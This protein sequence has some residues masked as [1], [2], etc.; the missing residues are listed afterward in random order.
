V[1]SAKPSSIFDRRSGTCGGNACIRGTRLEPRRVYRAFMSGVSIEELR[2]YFA[3]R[4]LTTEEVEACIRRC[5]RSRK[6]RLV[7]C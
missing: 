7:K 4:E 3:T 1:T 2:T 5:M 6:A